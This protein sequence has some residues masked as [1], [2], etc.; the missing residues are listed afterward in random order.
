[1]PIKRGQD[2][3]RERKGEER[4]RRVARE[5]RRWLAGVERRFEGFE[6]RDGGG[7]DVR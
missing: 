1:M 2:G 6:A 4:R 3:K 5:G 7:G